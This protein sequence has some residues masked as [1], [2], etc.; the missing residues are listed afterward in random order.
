MLRPDA[1][2][3]TFNSKYDLNVYLRVRIYHVQMMPLLNGAG[4]SFLVRLLQICRTYG[5]ET[6]ESS[7]ILRQG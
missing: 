3:P 5:A 4:K 7:L 6:V 2:L 1:A